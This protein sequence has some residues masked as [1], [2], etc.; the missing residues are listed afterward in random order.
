[1]FIMIVC[2]NIFSYIFLYACYA[3]VNVS[4][5]MYTTFSI[6]F[7]Y[8]LIAGFSFADIY[9]LPSILLVYLL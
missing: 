7:L 6:T 3:Y 5:C 2:L 9:I 8:I 1:M 4:K